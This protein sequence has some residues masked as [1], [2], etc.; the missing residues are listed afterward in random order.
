MDDTILI[1]HVFG[2]VMRIAIPL[3]IRIRTLTDG[4]E[5]ETEEDFYPNTSLPIEVVLMRDGGVSKKYTPQV[6]GNVITFE[7]DGTLRAGK[8][9]ITIT[10]Y[11]NNNRPYRYMAR[12]VIQ[13]VLATKDAGIRAGVEFDSTDYVLD[14][15]VYFYA[16][17]DKGDDGDQGVSVLSVQQISTST[18]SGGV[19][20]VRVTLSNGNVSDFE[21]RNGENVHGT[22]QGTTLYI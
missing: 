7:D 17:G 2:N 21:I 9:Q 16:K 19:N 8:Y 14:G 3:T 11:D 12:G 15:A 20:V 4:E 10:C 1:K 22:V 6:D 18:E 5:T 13:V